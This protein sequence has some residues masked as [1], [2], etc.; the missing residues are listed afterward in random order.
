[1]IF[2]D[3][4]S[5]RMFILWSFS[6]AFLQF[7]YYGVSNWLPAYLESDL[8]IKFKEMTTYMI[9]TFLIMMCTKVI[10]GIIADKIGRR[11][12][13]AFGTMGT[14]IFI[15]LYCLWQHTGQYLM[16]DAVFGFLY[17]I[18]Y[19]INATYMTESFSTKGPWYSYRWRL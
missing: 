9:G 1:M 2:A 4:L 16:A 3:A 17:G 8:G 6:T 12:V 10:A 11:A 5:R 14:A 18:P 13:F 7:G 19:G 15:P